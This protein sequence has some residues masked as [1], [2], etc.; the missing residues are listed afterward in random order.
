MAVTRKV[1]GQAAVF[2]LI[3]I[4][5][6]MLL[7]AMAADAAAVAAMRTE[8]NA[9]A[10]SIARYA[11]IDS[12]QMACYDLEPV[13][14]GDH[15]N[16]EWD[17]NAECSAPTGAVPAGSWYFDAEIVD[18]YVVDSATG[19]ADLTRLVRAKENFGDLV[20]RL[21]ENV[22]LDEMRATQMPGA[23]QGDAQRVRV[24]VV[25]LRDRDEMLVTKIPLVGQALGV[26]SRGALAVGESTATVYVPE[27]GGATDQPVK[28]WCV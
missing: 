13:C 15:N 27:P 26:G 25:L 5:A 8:A 28:Y 14:D 24:A 6:F 19:A 17:R 4:P 9:L 21:P 7:L 1:G 22:A 16:G 23:L 18:D 10:A 20:D 12:T 11:A 2:A 3:A